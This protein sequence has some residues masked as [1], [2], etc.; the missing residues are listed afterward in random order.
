MQDSALIQLQ[1]AEQEANTY[2]DKDLSYE[3]KKQVIQFDTK[4]RGQ[5]VSTPEEV[6]MLVNQ[7]QERL[8]NQLKDNVRIRLI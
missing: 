1:E 6:K 3:T 2:L 8:L 4:L 5:E 7:L